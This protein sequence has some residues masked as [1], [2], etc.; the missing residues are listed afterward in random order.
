MMRIFDYCFYHVV[1]GNTD[2]E[3]PLL[4]VYIE[5]ILVAAFPL[6]WNLITL[7]IWLPILP[8]DIEYQTMWNYYY[9]MAG[10]LLVIFSFRYGPRR[11]KKL[12]ER[13]GDKAKTTKGKLL[14][15]G[16]TFS[17]FIVGFVSL[18]IRWKT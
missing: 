5:G 8:Q 7:S 15:L 10:V 1:R 18:Y 16:Y 4:V 9:Q 11:Y 14:G 17:S 6:W 13:W 12:V 3:H 2:D